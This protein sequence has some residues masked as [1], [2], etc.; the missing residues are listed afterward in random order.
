MTYPPFWTLS[1]RFFTSSCGLVHTVSKTADILTCRGNPCPTIERH[2]PA[3]IQ[4]RRAHPKKWKARRYGQSISLALTLSIYAKVKRKTRPITRTRLPFARR[5]WHPNYVPGH[6]YLPS[7]SQTKPAPKKSSK[8]EPTHIAKEQPASIADEIPIRS[9][10]LRKLERQVDELVQGTKWDLLAILG[11]VNSARTEQRED[12]QKLMVF[13]RGALA[14]ADTVQSTTLGP[15]RSEAGGQQII[16]G[17]MGS[18]AVDA[19]AWPLGPTSWG[20]NLAVGSTVDPAL[21]P[22]ISTLRDE[23]SVARQINEALNPFSSKSNGLIARESAI[24]LK[25]DLG[26]GWYHGLPS[27]RHQHATR[28]CERMSQHQ[29][30]R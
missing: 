4:P 29:Q 5:P 17:Q 2:P 11:E 18:S 19:M 25:N 27:T 3:P 16:G 1:Y 6:R 20:E 21:F 10:Q 14:P 8:M 23:S 28:R 9:R 22:D 15:L 7:A 30:R 13:V 24:R 26:S 12:D